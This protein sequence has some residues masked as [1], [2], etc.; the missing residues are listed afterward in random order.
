VVRA[1]PGKHPKPLFADWLNLSADVSVHRARLLAALGQARAAA[2]EYEPTNEALREALS[3][4]SQLSDSKLVAGLLGCTV[5]SNFHFFR[6]KEAAAD[7]FR[8]EQSAKAETSPWQRALQSR[9]LRQ[10]LLFLGH[11]DEAASITGLLEP[12]ARWI[13]QSYS[14]AL[15]LSSRAWVEFGTTPDLAKLETDLRLAS[16]SGQTE[17]LRTGKLSSRYNQVWQHSFA[18]TGQAHCPMLKVR[19]ARSWT[20]LPASQLRFPGG[21]SYG[22]DGLAPVVQERMP[23]IDAPRPDGVAL[24]KAASLGR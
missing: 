3:I 16:T 8:S 6:L 7:G 11:L 17:G 14:I 9:I 4:A 12:L 24:R 19:A 23:D 13:G 15:S 5:H 10:S 2:G 22:R 18:E 1:A 20:R 21:G